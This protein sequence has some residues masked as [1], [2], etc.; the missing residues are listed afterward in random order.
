MLGF[1]ETDDLLG[2]FDKTVQKNSVSS[3]YVNERGHRILV[4]TD[5]K[6]NTTC[7]RMHNDVESWCG[8]ANTAEDHI[9]PVSQ[10][11]ESESIC[12]WWFY[13]LLLLPQKLKPEKG[14]IL[15]FVSC[16]FCELGWTKHQR[17]FTRFPAR[18]AECQIYTDVFMRV[19][20]LCKSLSAC[21]MLW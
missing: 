20:S 15:L 13:A 12:I 17:C 7:I 3:S 2:F 10:E 16:Q 19:W 18:V 14:E 6:S 11:E 8:W 1:L 5:R 21:R 9:T 4:R